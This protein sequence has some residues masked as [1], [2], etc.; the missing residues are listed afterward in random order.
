MEQEQ[1]YVNPSV[2]RIGSIYFDERNNRVKYF[3]TD[4]HTGAESIDFLLNQAETLA[5]QNNATRINARF[6]SEGNYSGNYDANVEAR[7]PLNNGYTGIEL[8]FI[9]INQP[10]RTSTREINDAEDEI[11]RN[12]VSGTR[13]SRSLSSEYRIERL[14]LENLTEND[15]SLMRDLYRESFVTYTTELNES[16]IRDM[17]ENSIVYAVRNNG[18]IVS[19]VVAEIANIPTANGNFRICELSEMAT[20]REHRGQGLVTLA[21]EAL[22]EEIYPTVNLIY[23]EARACHQ[24]INNSFRNMGFEYAGRLNKQCILS[25]DHEVQEEGPYENLNVWY[26][27]GDLR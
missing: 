1:E 23:A 16:S 11:I 3:S 5:E 25:G 9:G 24:A 8:L 14:S 13:K 12:A 7:I 22:I 17:V 4:I 26:L 2:G 10:E 6:F 18:T 27:L 21:T 15:I 20:L 19:T